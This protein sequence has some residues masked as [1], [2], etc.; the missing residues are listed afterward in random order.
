M[1]SRL[2]KALLIGF[3]LSFSVTLTAFS[4][5]EEEQIEVLKDVSN[6]CIE[7][8]R[9]CLFKT[10]KG[11]ELNAYTDGVTIFIYTGI[12]ERL[13]KDELRSILYHELSHILLQHPQR[14]RELFSRGLPI[15]MWEFK[16]H[17]VYNEV[18]ADTLATHLLLSKGYPSNLD[19]GLLRIV[20]KEFIGKQTLTHPSTISRVKNIRKIEVMYERKL[21]VIEIQDDIGII[22]YEKD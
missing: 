7:N 19:E 14:T 3:I 18:E 8:Q 1:I 15:S 10:I 11:N 4:A 6:T 2:L 16:N 20:P 21:E 12:L 9:V 13:S 22:E 5:T 17:K